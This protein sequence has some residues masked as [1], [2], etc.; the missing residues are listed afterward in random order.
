MTKLF[1][2]DV[3]DLER[4]TLK[5]RTA[6]T[7]FFR[8]EGDS[9]PNHL[10]QADGVFNPEFVMCQQAR[11]LADHVKAVGKPLFIDDIYAHPLISRKDIV[12]GHCIRA[13]AGTPVFEDSSVVRGVLCT[14]DNSKRD[15]SGEDM[16]VLRAASR[17]LAADLEYIECA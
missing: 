16:T 14:V 17:C 4:I 7:Y 12:F 10:L 13:F 8:W 3:Q 11:V 1:A 6:R 5:L 9:E 15:W 2:P